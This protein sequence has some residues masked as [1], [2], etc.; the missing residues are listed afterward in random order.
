MLPAGQ[1]DI[2]FIVRSV[3]ESLV[4]RVLGPALTW[5]SQLDAYELSIEA[6]IKLAP[7]G[8]V[9]PDDFQYREANALDP[10]IVVEQPNISLYC[11]DHQNRHALFVETP[12]GMDLLHAPF[13]FHAQ[14][15]AAQR[16]I[17]IPYDTLHALASEV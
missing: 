3:R 15:E 5:R 7:F 1:H 14:Y 9:S 16:L 6:R 4:D 8:I 13:Y 12:A 11:L 10:R 2:V 17:A